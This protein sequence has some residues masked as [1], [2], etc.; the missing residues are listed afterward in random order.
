MQF[1]QTIIFLSKN[2]TLK[3]SKNIIPTLYFL[4]FAYIF[5]SLAGSALESRK[6]FLGLLIKQDTAFYDAFN[7]NEFEKTFNNRFI[8]FGFR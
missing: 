1:Q 5:A 2:Y 6:I 7:Y 4:C 8:Y 3:N